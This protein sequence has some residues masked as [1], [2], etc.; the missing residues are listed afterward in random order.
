MERR[1]GIH[2]FPKNLGNCKLQ[3]ILFRINLLCKN[4]ISVYD[5]IAK[6]W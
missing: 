4:W 5:V 2:C 3:Y 6:E 1:P